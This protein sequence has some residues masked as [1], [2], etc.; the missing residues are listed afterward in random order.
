[1][2][3]HSP[4][5]ASAKAYPTAFLSH[6]EICIGIGIAFGTFVLPGS[7]GVDSSDGSEPSVQLTLT[8]LKGGQPVVA[9]TS[10]TSL[11]AGSARTIRSTRAHCPSSCPSWSTT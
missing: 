7:Y 3:D 11:V 10:R 5:T 2:A 8:G 6:A 1:M 9:R 4:S